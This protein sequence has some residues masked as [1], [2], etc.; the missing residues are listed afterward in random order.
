MTYFLTEFG[1]IRRVADFKHAAPAN[2]SGSN[3]E[4]KGLDLQL[5]PNEVFLCDAA[6]ESLK[7]FAIG[8]QTDLF[9]RFFVQKGR[10]CLKVGNYIGLIETPDGTQLE[11]LPKI[12]QTPAEGRAMVLKML[13]CLPDM[14]F[15]NLSVAH[16]QDGR[17]PLWEV[18]VAAFVAETEKIVQQGLQKCYVSVEENRCFLSGKLLIEKQIAQNSFH[19]EKFATIHDE[20]WE[21]I[22]PNRL[23]KTCILQ[24]QTGSRSLANQTKLRQLRFVFEQVPVSA[25][26]E[27]DF[28]TA[29]QTDRRFDRYATALQWA[30]VLLRGRSW[31][32]QAGKSLNMSL[33]FPAERLFEAYVARGFRQYLRGYEVV[34]QDKSRHLINDHGGDGKCR[35]RPDLVLRKNDQTLVLDTKWKWIDATQ[36]TKNYGIDQADLYQ[37]YAYGQKYE[38]QE[39]CLIYPKNASFTAPLAVFE[40]QPSLRLRVLPFDIALPLAEAVAILPLLPFALSSAT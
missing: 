2:P 22:A 37:L 38:A 25:N 27:T 11:V 8:Q 16:L 29:Q 7:A 10:E 4:A 24:L 20:F 18:F 40:Y 19:Q 17:L 23:L 1:T 12:A 13:R 3:A 6:F 31:V 5:L 26:V 14:P 35:L 32:G 28:R 33:L 9:L 34:L 39:V 21:N 15:R 30:A 36:T